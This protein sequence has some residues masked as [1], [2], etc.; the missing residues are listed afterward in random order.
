MLR[1]RSSLQLQACDESLQLP[2][3]SQS[4][5]LEALRDWAMR[6]EPNLAALCDRLAS[7]SPAGASVLLPGPT[8]ERNSYTV[9]AREPSCASRRPKGLARATR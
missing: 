7:L 8:G 2:R 1:S 9:L 5:A 3:G 6:S 4:D